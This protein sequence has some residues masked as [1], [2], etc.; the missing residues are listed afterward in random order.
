MIISSQLMQP[1]FR[2]VVV[3]DGYYEWKRDG[4]KKKP[5]FLYTDQDKKVRKYAFA[6]NNCVSTSRLRHCEKCIG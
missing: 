3:C 1:S 4:N 6:G 2:C 5:Y